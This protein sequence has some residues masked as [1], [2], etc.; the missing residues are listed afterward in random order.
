MC[1]PLFHNNN[2]NLTRVLQHALSALRHV[3]NNAAVFGDKK[4][5]PIVLFS[6]ENTQALRLRERKLTAHKAA[7]ERRA[8]KTDGTNPNSTG[9]AAFGKPAAISAPAV[10]VDR[11]DGK[12]PVKMPAP[13]AP[14]HDRK[15]KAD[16]DSVLPA[17]RTTATATASTSKPPQPQQQQL[18]AKKQNQQLQQQERATPRGRAQRED[19]LTDRLAEGRPL[20]KRAPDAT[21]VDFEPVLKRRRGIDKV[22]HPRQKNKKS[23]LLLIEYVGDRSAR[24]R[25]NSICL[26]EN[27]GNS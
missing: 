23:I 22:Y 25:P 1:W 9:K 4:R 18:S 15:R 8:A 17:K 12:L 7:E 19:K 21:A 24:P 10:V 6:W 16:S 3:N 14:R 11:G 5:R 2:K 26:L 27:I 20:S 13:A